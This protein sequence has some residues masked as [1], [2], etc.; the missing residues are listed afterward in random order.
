MHPALLMAATAPRVTTPAGEVMIASPTPPSPL[1]MASASFP[2]RL[3]IV[4]DAFQDF[5]AFAD[6]GAHFL[7]MRLVFG[8]ASDADHLVFGGAFDADHLGD[9]LRLQF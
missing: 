5:A 2:H 1:R 7:N 4:A 6:G 9:L 3:I 8:G